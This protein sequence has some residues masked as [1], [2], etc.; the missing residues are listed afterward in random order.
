MNRARARRSVGL[1][2][3]AAAAL[4]AAAI[5]FFADGAAAAAPK[6]VLA[7]SDAPGLR[8]RPARP[9]AAR[10]A[11]AKAL[12]LAALPRIPATSTQVAHL[13]RGQAELW[14][15]AF[16]LRSPGAARKAANG[17][18]GSA[19]RAKQAVSRARIGNGGFV[20]GAR[21]AGGRPVAVLWRRGS[22]LG[23]I[24][25][26]AP[27]DPRTL[28]AVA[29][30]YARVADRLMEGELSKT[31]WERALGGIGPRGQVSRKTALD[32]FA[33]AYG[34]LP[35][36]KPPAGP[37]GPI[38][39]G[40][41]AAQL[42]LRYWRTLSKTQQQA[43]AKLLGAGNVRLSRRASARRPAREDGAAGGDRSNG[44]RQV[45]LLPCGPPDPNAPDAP[46]NATF[47]DPG[48]V[49]DPGLQKLANEFQLIY[50]A[51]L[52]HTL[53]LSICAG[54]APTLKT[55]PTDKEGFADA[56]SVDPDGYKPDGP[57][58]RI[59]VGPLGQKASSVFQKLVIAHEVFHCY[60][61]DIIGAGWPSQA[62]WVMEGMADWAALTVDPV[63]WSIGGGNIGNYLASC[64]D[65]PLLSRSYDAVGFFGH[66]DDSVEP[67]FQRAKSVLLAKTGLAA[68]EAAGGGLPAFLGSWASSALVLPEVGLEWMSFRPI[69]APAGSGCPE[70]PIWQDSAIG[71]D[72]FTTRSYR[73]DAAFSNE[74]LLHVEVFKGRARVGDGIVDEVV[75]GDAWFCLAG[76]CE[77]PAGTEGLPPPAPKLDVPAHVALTGGKTTGLGQL[78]FVPLKQ[79]CKEKQKPPPP[80]GGGAGGS[81]GG[82]GAGEAAPEPVN[83]TG[84]GCGLSSADPHL[85]PFGGLW[86]DFQ[87]VGE[88]TLVRSTVDDLEVQ[89]R[90]QP[91]PGS[92]VVSMNTA[93]AM[94][95]AGDRVAIYKGR[96]LTVRV[97]GRQVLLG[98]K[99]LRLPH[100]GTVKPLRRGEVEVVWPDGSVARVVPTLDLMIDVIVSLSSSRSG[101][102]TGLLGNAD[103][104]FDND[105]VTRRGRRL[106]SKLIRATGK[107]S[108][109]ALYRVF[110]DSWRITP[111]TSLFDYAPGQSTNTF[112]NRRFPA[113]VVS[114][115]T[116]P[117]AARR[118]AEAACRRLRIKAARV[119]ENCALDVASTGHLGFATAAATIEKSVRQKGGGGTK[120]SP[121][122]GG[123]AAGRWTVISTGSY[124]NPS[125]VVPSLALD[126]G[127]VVAAYATGDKTSEA[128]TFSAGTGGITGLRKSPIAA[129]ETAVDNP[130]LLPR[131]GWRATGSPRRH[132]ALRHLVCA[133]RPRWGLRPPGTRR[134]K[135][136]CDGPGPGRA[137]SGRRSALAGELRRPVAVEGRN[138]CRPDLARRRGVEVHARCG[139][140]FRRPLLAHVVPARQQDLGE[141][142]LRR[143][144]RPERAEA[145][146]GAEQGPGEPE[147]REQR[148]GALARVRR[149]VPARLRPRAG[150]P[151]RLV[152]ARKRCTGP[153]FAS[154]D[155]R[156]ARVPPGSRLYEHGEA[157]GRMVERGEEE[158]PR[159]SRERRWNR[160]GGPR[161]RPAGRGLTRSE[162]SRRRRRGPEPRARRQRRE[163]GKAGGAVR[164]RGLGER[165]SV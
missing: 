72:A 165:L 11:L 36:T 105:F 142:A 23:A 108:H 55:K 22:A 73:I 4:A 113:E 163:P 82:G 7:R 80:G 12:G 9:S 124:S 144:D 135:R 90:Q 74:P 47:G 39:S 107:R 118:T 94:R 65:T 147:H 42:I 2:A 32:L 48:F 106:D 125:L 13:G 45:R 54:T 114:A 152:V 123:G 87:A 68:Y 136:A 59:R 140:R 53:K 101:K 160:K 153:G 148:A 21:P 60:E 158:R 126:G 44:S 16:V 115:G 116:L 37:P 58:C 29:L 43:A 164:L 67:F 134:V 104:N 88:F 3:L 151:S 79:Y 41:L 24:V 85:L 132:P 34:P 15:I 81:P 25:F 71:A 137:R 99:E 57:F 138:R 121:P 83:C 161:A 102:V 120:P 131:P 64:S 51:K 49:Y 61:F 93:A 27:L 95:V 159:D 62:P 75:D 127:A 20:I 14:S 40:T 111:R 119:L 109:D 17:A 157:L 117:P 18:V 96:P 129:A 141:R 69:V 149:L 130:I 162:R 133:A 56:L 28:R 50:N 103:G 33:L 76:T 30:D 92:K 86:Y 77:C 10:S 110:G 155:G 35:G 1:A 154:A 63:P 78:T 66:V 6:L 52:K 38:L 139:T 143:P 84:F 122:P 26:V 146:G 98:K 8:P 112:T 31:A 100:G 89:V 128:A 156:S 91:W 5:G 70:V 97:N 145:S 19:R 150:R 46:A